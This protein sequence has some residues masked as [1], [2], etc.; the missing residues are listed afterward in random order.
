[1]FRKVLSCPSGSKQMG[2]LNDDMSGAGLVGHIFNLSIKG[3][4]DKCKKD[5]RCG[6]FHY[7]A[8]NVMFKITIF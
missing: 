6:S 4:Q 1:M 8:P 5:S 3:C 7:F 2:S